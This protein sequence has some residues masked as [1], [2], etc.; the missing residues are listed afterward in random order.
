M[1]WLGRMPGFAAIPMADLH[2]VV[3]HMVEHGYLTRSSGVLSFGPTS[4]R[5]FGGVHYRE[6]FSIFDSEPLFTVLLGRTELGRVHESTFQV[7]SG[8][9]SILLLAGRSWKVTHLDWGRAEAFVEPAEQGGKSRWKGSGQPLHFRLC[10]AIRRVLAGSSSRNGW[11]RRTRER[12]DTIR[13]GFDWL[14]EKGSVLL[15]DGSRK[16]AWWTFA[17]MLANASLAQALI[18]AGWLGASASDL[19]LTMPEERGGL[20][21]A[22]GDLRSAPQLRE[23]PAPLAQGAL[24]RLKFSACLP[25]ELAL[26]SL[27]GRLSDVAGVAAVLEEPLRMV[28]GSADVSGSSPGAT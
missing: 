5:V 8:G 18:D 12:M 4:E 20:D 9:E 16:A 24:E 13:S 22:L 15:R 25:R 11:S 1:R 21:A 23:A 17:G 19:S 10:R 27:A 2:A 28:T 6:L 7:A 26:A 3:E 14:D